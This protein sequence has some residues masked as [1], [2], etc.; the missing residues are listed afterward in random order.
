MT[1]TYFSLPSSSHV[2]GKHS[3][4]SWA[5]FEMQSFVVM[6]GRRQGKLK[7]VLTGE[8]HKIHQLQRT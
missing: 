4:K 1:L 5:Y 2:S 6:E 3:K 7:G 8:A